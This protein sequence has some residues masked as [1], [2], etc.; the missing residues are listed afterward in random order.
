MLEQVE[1]NMM[2]ISTNKF[3]TDIEEGEFQTWVEQGKI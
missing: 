3:F 1:T 2:N